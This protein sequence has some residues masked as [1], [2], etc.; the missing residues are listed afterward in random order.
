M[1]QNIV[2]KENHKVN[3]F[4]N[5]FAIKNIAIYIIS[6]MLSMVGIGG[7]FSVFSISMLGACFASSVP[8]L[9]VMIASLIGN[10]IKYGVGGALGYFLTSLILVITLVVIKPR[11]NEKERNEKIKIGK[12]IF[13]F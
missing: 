3:I 1:L 12:N 8:A 5:V 4:S 10:L 7:E 9:G 11:Y 2:E 13:L 6:L